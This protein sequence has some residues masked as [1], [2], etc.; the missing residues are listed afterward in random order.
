MKK[1][2]GFW[3]LLKDAGA[4]FSRHKVLKL[5]ASLAYYTIFSIGPMLLVIIFFANL[6]WGRAA[7][8]GKIYSQISGTVGDGAAHQIQDI[9]KNAS[10][11]G[12]NFTAIIGF[13]TLI[14][15]AT[16]AFIE[17]QDSLNMIWNLKVK[18]DTGWKLML[19]NR[20]LSFS[21][22]AGL[23]FFL[24]VSL[25]INALLEGF[26]G[27]LQQMFPQISVVFMYV[28]NLLL[29]LVVVAGLFAI[30]FKVLPDAL[31]KWKDV[32]AGALFTA[33]LFMLGKFCITFYISK[34]NM[35]STY[36]T[37]GSLVVLLLWIYYSSAILYFG[38]EFTK[39]YAI[40][41]GSEIR[42][43][44]YAVTM[45]VVNVESSESSI[46]QNEKN[47]ATTEKE[48][49]RVKDSSKKTS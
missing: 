36:G 34:S 21:I 42:P 23:G 33:I 47:A 6:F 20:L 32:A 7:I 44:K 38:A 40:K 25:V 9:I 29:T 1:I 41:Y 8:E 39:A 2:K 13:V 15:A 12:N 31:I 30:I 49:Q 37:A 19:K 16:T 14:V 26:M 46:Q 35:G 43:D 18:E 22:V 48:V 10:I 17:M 5:S 45:Q 24:L 28:F 11:T 3:Q 27:K 4:G